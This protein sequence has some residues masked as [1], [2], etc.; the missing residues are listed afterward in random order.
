[1]QVTLSNGDPRTPTPTSRWDYR[2]KVLI[3]YHYN[4]PSSG[5]YEFRLNT[6]KKRCYLLTEMCFTHDS[7]VK[8][9]STLTRMSW[10]RIE[11]AQR[12]RKLRWVRFESS[13]GDWHDLELSQL[14]TAWVKNEWVNHSPN[15]KYFGYVHSVGRKNVP[16]IHQTTPHGHQFLA[17]LIPALSRALLGLVRTLPSF[18]VGGRC[19]LRSAPPSISVT[20]RRRVKIQTGIESPGRNLSY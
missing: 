13:H 4:Y 12:I 10:V 5:R 19:V 18:G 3:A 15:C 14:E 2:T 16:Q 1:M 7:W 17:P 9:D 20:N 11:P 6:Y 8:F